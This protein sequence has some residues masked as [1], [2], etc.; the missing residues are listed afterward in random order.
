V[1]AA[2]PTFILAS[3]PISV[4]GWGTREAAAVAAFAAVG[5]PAPAA[6]AMALLY[7]LAALVQA[8]AGLWDLLGQRDR[9]TA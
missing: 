4:G 3:L 1:V 6:V 2:A 5:V 7:G 9:P 8:V